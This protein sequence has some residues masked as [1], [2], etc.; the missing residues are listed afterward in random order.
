MPRLFIFADEAGCFNFSNHPSAS[1][2]FI[3]CTI[4]CDSC[5]IGTEL[6]DLR[7][8]L[9][10]EKAPVRE[11]FHASSDKQAIRDRV[12]QVLQG[13]NFSIQ[14]TILEKAKAQPK[15]RPTKNRFYKYGWYLHFKFVAPKITH[16]ATELQITT[17]SVGTH[18]GQAAFTSAVNDVVQQVIHGKTWVTNFCRSAADPCLQA[19][20]YCTWA[21][22]RKWE[23]GD[24]R[25][26]D[27]IK[28]KLIHEV[29]SW[30]HGKKLY[31]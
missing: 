27:L 5:A 22:Q 24:D 8:Q 29:D 25:S 3:V 7:R 9:I 21:I 1:R 26:Y 10:W 11:F 16:I 15:T 17:A 2:Y 13:Q 30:A 31:Y 14:A 4:A 23:S 28:S 20:D 19:V 18:K 12:F 6:L